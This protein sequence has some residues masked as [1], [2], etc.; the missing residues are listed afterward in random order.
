M[1]ILGSNETKILEIAMAYQSD[2]TDGV[3]Q[4]NYSTGEL[5][6]G[7]FTTGTVENPKNLVIEVYRLPQGESGKIDFK[8]EDCFVKDDEISYRH[9][10]I[11]AYIY[12]G[13]F[14]DDFEDNYRESVEMQIRDILHSHLSDTIGKLNEIRIGISD[15]VAPYNYS[16]VRNSDWE[17]RVLDSYVDTAMED[18]FTLVPPTDYLDGE[19]EE[20]ALRCENSYEGIE[21]WSEFAYK[22]REKDLDGALEML[23]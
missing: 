6:G 9:C 7:A 11:N 21:F 14:E 3:V 20:I 2:I 18:G 13:Y 16:R 15:I 4:Y 1:R 8:C 22:M 17:M 19:I 10:C 12:D 5:C 23:H